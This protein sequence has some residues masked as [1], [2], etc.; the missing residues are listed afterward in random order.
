MWWPGRR[1]Q[2]AA[3]ARA[4]VVSGWPRR[5]WG[6]AAVSK[7][8]EAE[9][10]KAAVEWWATVLRV[11]RAVRPMARVGFYNFPS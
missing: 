4:R 11:T 5:G 6:A 7:Q 8:A 1:S 9:G 10:G 2:A 3:E